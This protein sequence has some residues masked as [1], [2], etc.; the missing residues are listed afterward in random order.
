LFFGKCVF[1][2]GAIFNKLAGLQS[3]GCDF[4]KS[5]GLQKRVNGRVSGIAKTRERASE[6]DCEN[7]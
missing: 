4:K 5:V 6:W 1:G 7:V 3:A 2:V